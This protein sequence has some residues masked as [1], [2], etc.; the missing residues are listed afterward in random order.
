[1]SKKLKTAYSEYLYNKQNPFK[2]QITDTTAPI[3]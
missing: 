1:M 2:T 3:L